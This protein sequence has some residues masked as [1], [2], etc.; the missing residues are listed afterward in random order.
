MYESAS[1]HVFA[2]EAEA[3]QCSLLHL[4]MLGTLNLQCRFRPLVSK[5]HQIFR[6]EDFTA[7]AWVACSYSSSVKRH[8]VHLPNSALSAGY[9]CPSREPEQLLCTR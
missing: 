3:M 8:S 9:D 1:N 2:I 5:G 4:F 6:H 7:C